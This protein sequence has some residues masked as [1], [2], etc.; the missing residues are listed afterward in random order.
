VTEIF[1]TRVLLL[2]SAF[3]NPGDLPRGGTIAITSTFHSN[4]RS[5]L[6]VS[7]DCFSYEW[8][9]VTFANGSGGS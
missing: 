6:V 8:L 3:P 4:V 7:E 1:A 9:S 2:S 5:A